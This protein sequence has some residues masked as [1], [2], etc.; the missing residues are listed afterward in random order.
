MPTHKELIAIAVNQAVKDVTEIIAERSEAIRT[1]CESAGISN[2]VEVK[3]LPED[4]RLFRIDEAVKEIKNESER[5]AMVNALVA[6][7][8]ILVYHKDND[9]R[10]KRLFHEHATDGQKIVRVSINIQ[11]PS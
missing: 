6:V 1:F 2:Q 10:I 5:G 7:F 9:E 4:V 11:D 8:G 3:H